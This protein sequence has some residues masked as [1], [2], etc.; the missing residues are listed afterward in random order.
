MKN[1]TPNDFYEARNALGLSLAQ[2][3]RESGINRNFLSNFEKKKHFLSAQALAKLRDFYLN[4]DPS[5][6]DGEEAPEQLEKAEPEKAKSD[7]AVIAE[8]PVKRD[9]VS[10]LAEMG[11]RLVDGRYVAPSETDED[12][13][14]VAREAMTDI[15]DELAKLLK[16][17]LPT[18]EVGFFSY[19]KELDQKQAFDSAMR[20]VIL[21]ARKQLE[22]DKMQGF[23]QLEPT[24]GE[25]VSLSVSGDEL[26]SVTVG[27][28]ATRLLHADNDW[29]SELA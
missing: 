7:V 16:V 11:Y 28:Y 24:E 21:L 14:D 29:L 9:T 19:D 23:A 13:I 22:H 4:I 8:K 2:V 5:V 10:L 25:S 15:D 26:D 12:L 17:P 6:F 27:Q 1:L 18:K 3:A 20:V